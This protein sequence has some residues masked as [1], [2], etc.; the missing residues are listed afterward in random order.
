MS[1]KEDIEKAD[2]QRAIDKEVADLEEQE[3]KDLLAQK[4]KEEAEKQRQEEEKER[5]RIAKETQLAETRKASAAEKSASALQ[6]QASAAQN[7]H[8]DLFRQ[9]MQLLMKFILSPW[10]A[11]G[12]Y[13]AVFTA[14]LC[15]VYIFGAILGN[16][17]S[18]QASPTQQRNSTIGFRY[19][20]TLWDRI[21]SW[22]VIPS[23]FKRMVRKF[24]PSN[25][26]LG[27][28][29]D[30]LDSGRCDGAV[31]TDMPN[32]P[33]HCR[34]Y[35]VPED[36]PWK[37]SGFENSEYNKMPAEIKR[38]YQDKTVIIPWDVNPA[39]S[40]Y[41][42]QC[43]KAYFQDMCRV[44]SDS[45]KCTSKETASTGTGVNGKRTTTCC[46]KANLLVDNGTSCSLKELPRT[47]YKSK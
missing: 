37:I 10:P 4:Q 39:A 17:N 14:L 7:A 23:S 40:F 27:T 30:V 46:A 13:V 41:V 26:G 38:R 8:P 47:L 43:E 25:D 45:S 44:V 31:W 35:T 9:F 16:K 12:P 18:S 20:D 33:G 6:K 3:E 5:E 34:N 19:K 21:A 1:S 29:R 11:F 42:P 28:P 24:K 2:K 32:D 15:M 36:I 22:F